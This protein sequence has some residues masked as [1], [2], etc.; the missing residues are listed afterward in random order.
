MS[1]SFD[2]QKTKF[3]NLLTEIKALRNENKD[4]KYHIQ[5]LEAKLDDMETKEKACNIIVS[6]VPKQTD[7]NPRNIMSK[8]AKTIKV[9]MDSNDIL[10][11]FR[12]QSRDDGPILVKFGKVQV[13]KD[14]LKAIKQEKG[15]SIKK[16]GLEGVDRK[17][18]LNEDLPYSKRVLFKKARDVKRDKGY[19][20]A[21]CVNGIVYIKKSDQDNP[22]RIKTEGDLLNVA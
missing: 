9:Q 6:G 7:P 3:D 15:T 19:K 13:K 2:E 4:L 18:Y 21:F 12:L 22:V 8:I 5:T 17:I 20:A 11:C 14:L 10:E 1:N 16:C